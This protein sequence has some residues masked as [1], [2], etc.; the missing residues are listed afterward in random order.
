MTIDDYD[1]VVELW[2]RAEG[3]GLNESDTQPAIASFLQRNCGLSLVVEQGGRIVGAVLCGHDGR[4]GYL[5]HLA[6]DTD[7]RGCGI[8]RA[9]VEKCL[10]SL[11]SLGISKA[12]IFVFA[13]NDAGQRF[14]R[15]NAWKGRTDLLVMQRVLTPGAKACGC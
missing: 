1:A 9:L 3:V 15:H 6:V 4:R 8:G 10:A 5:H 2:S 11:A 7:S 12:N 13:D 14:W